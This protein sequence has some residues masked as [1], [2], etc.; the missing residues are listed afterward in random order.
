MEKWLE[1]AIGG[2][3]STAT[4]IIILSYIPIIRSRKNNIVTYVSYLSYLY[5]CFEPL[6]DSLQ[7]LYHGRDIGLTT[8]MAAYKSFIGLKNDHIL[9]LNIDLSNDNLRFAMMV[10]ANDMQEY[11]A[12]LCENKTIILNKQSDKEKL[13][14]IMIKTYI[15]GLKLIYF[16]LVFNDYC[17]KRYNKYSIDIEMNKR[18]SIE[19]KKY[20]GN[21]T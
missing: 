12:I 9:K 17:K 20:I 4:S 3:V 15:F 14:N 6:K 8:S 21:D 7:R 18:I 13:V 2:I 5:E 10:F 19:K 16:I 11:I 1:S